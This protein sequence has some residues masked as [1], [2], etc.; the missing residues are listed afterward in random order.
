M[1]FSRPSFLADALSARLS[2]RAALAGVPAAALL[3][4]SGA[5]AQDSTPAGLAMP[6]ANAIEFVGVIQQ[7]GLDFTL[8]GYVTHFD[9]IEP[10]L[11]FDGA[12][13]LSRSQAP[14]PGDPSRANHRVPRLT[15]GSRYPWVSVA[16]RYRRP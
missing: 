10:S 8:M 15:S 3:P 4:A 5:T 12:D 13:P 1:K 14:L 6:A 16:P 7:L 2:R 11:L 9:G